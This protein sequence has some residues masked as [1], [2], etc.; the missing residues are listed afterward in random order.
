MNVKRLF[1]EIAKH[2]RLYIVFVRYSIMSQMEYRTN[3]VTGIFMEIGFTFM[4][5]LYVVV[6]Y[7]T[8]RTFAGFAPD[9]IL[10]FSGTFIIAT[11]FYVG[12]YVMNFLDIREHIRLGTLDLLMTKPVSLQFLLTLRRSD[13]GMFITDFTAGLIVVVIAWQRLAIPV[14]VGTLLGYAGLLLVGAVT[15]YALFLMPQLLAFWFVRANSLFEVA[16]AFWDFN[17]MP[18]VSYNRIVQLV[19]LVVIPIFMVTNMPPLF[20]L[21]KM[22]VEHYILIIVIPIGFLFAS[23]LLF[24]TALKRY[25]SAGA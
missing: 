15:G 22:K 7:Q 17:I 6:I 5:I 19:G 1:F 13:P 8:G 12:M 11:S 3:F 14:T 2:I 25:T 24:K 10:L 16:D 4:K 21:G 9:E 20:V 23:R 18:M